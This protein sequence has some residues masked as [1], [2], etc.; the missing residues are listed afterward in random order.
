[1]ASLWSMIQSRNAGDLNPHIICAHCQWS[2]CV[3]V[4][5]IRKSVG[6]SGGKATAALIT[7]GLSV[8]ATGLSRRE[9]MTQCSC[10]VC[11]SVWIQ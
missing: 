3:R 1:M 10:D 11:K 8:L 6:I 7:G 9:T 5:P 4:K 2:N